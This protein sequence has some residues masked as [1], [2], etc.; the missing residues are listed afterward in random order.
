[1]KKPSSKKSINASYMNTKTMVLVGL[2]LVLLIAFGTYLYHQHNNG[3]ASKEDFEKAQASIDQL[4]NNIMA[5]LGPPANY[6]K[7]QSCS[8]PSQK[9]SQGPLS[10]SVDKDIFYKIEGPLFAEKANSKVDGAINSSKLASPGSLSEKFTNIDRGTSLQIKYYNLINTP[11]VCV[12]KKSYDNPAEFPQNI[13]LTK[14]INYY[15]GIS[16]FGESQS[17]FFKK[18]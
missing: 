2:V 3:K 15:V 16:C 18:V 10:C 12:V 13:S 17:N 4:Y 14:N 9:F 5:K 8:R 11:L 6:K 1:M 7:T